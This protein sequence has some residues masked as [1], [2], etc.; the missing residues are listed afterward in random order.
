VLCA[1]KMSGARPARLNNANSSIHIRG[2]RQLLV[3]FSE[4]IGSCCC[5]LKIP[6]PVPRCVTTL[7]LPGGARGS[8]Y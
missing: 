7:S 1:R 6:L 4:I 2:L 3:Q 5:L 8:F